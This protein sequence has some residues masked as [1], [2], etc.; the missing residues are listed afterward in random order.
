[1]KEKTKV[2]T[3]WGD[4]G[5]RD[6]DDGT[7]YS[8]KQVLRGYERLNEEINDLA[9]VATICSVSYAHIVMPLPF[10]YKVLRLFATVV[11]SLPSSIKDDNKSSM[12][13]VDL[14]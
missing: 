3:L 14:T 2:L 9:K 10:P 4:C 7:G 12:R 6:P 11:Y 1:M 8:S 5:W 13:E